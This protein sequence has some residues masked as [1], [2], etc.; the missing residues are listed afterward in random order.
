MADR[1]QSRAEPKADQGKLYWHVLLRDHPQ[2]RALASEAQERLAR[3]AGFHFT[4]MEWLHVTTL[5]VGFSDKFTTA[6]IDGMASSARMLVSGMAPIT[7]TF[8]KV[9]Y[10][11]EAIAIGLRPKDSLDP[12]RDAVWRATSG[13]V[14]SGRILDDQPWNPHFTVAYS[15]A[16]QPAAPIIGALGRELPGGQATIGRVN[17]VLQQG[18]ERLWDWRTIAEADLGGT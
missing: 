3:F 11:P 7:V 17:L 12:V 2:L 16:V 14:G 9:L 1:W 18:A 5:V 10:H 13:V 15:N 4:P 8:G 6:E